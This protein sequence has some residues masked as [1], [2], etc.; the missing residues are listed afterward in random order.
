VLLLRTLKKKQQNDSLVTRGSM[1]SA[2]VCCTAGPEFTPAR[3][4]SSQ[5]A[6]SY[7]FL[8]FLAWDGSPSKI[9][10]FSP[11]EKKF[12]KIRLL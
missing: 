10:I 2:P 8:I 4:A 1:V 6:F 12:V 5:L 3:H 7:I 11:S 9:F